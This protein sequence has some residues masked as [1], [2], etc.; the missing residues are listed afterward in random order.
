MSV[1]AAGSSASSLL[2]LVELLE[3]DVELAALVVAGG[4]LGVDRRALDAAAL[5]AASARLCGS[6]CGGGVCGDLSWLDAQPA[7]D[8]HGGGDR[9]VSGAWTTSVLLLAISGRARRRMRVASGA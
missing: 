8:E 5:P 2:R 7:S 4:E 6:G 1:D 9:D 3:R